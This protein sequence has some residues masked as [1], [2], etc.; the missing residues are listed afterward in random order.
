MGTEL[1]QWDGVD[2]TRHVH[3]TVTDQ[4]LYEMK[5]EQIEM[6]QD[7]VFLIEAALRGSVDGPL[8]LPLTGLP[9]R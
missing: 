4:D 5:R 6:L 9:V 8:T 3:L 7:A 2:G 1:R